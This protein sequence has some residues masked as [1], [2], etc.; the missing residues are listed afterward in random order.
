MTMA[1][2]RTTPPNPVV[3]PPPESNAL[4]PMTDEER[5]VWNADAVG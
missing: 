2:D 1:A 4:I 5:D 3:E